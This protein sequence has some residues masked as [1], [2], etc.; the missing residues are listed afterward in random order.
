MSDLEHDPADVRALNVDRDAR[1][2]MAALVGLAEV[3]AY[4]ALILEA[5]KLLASALQALHDPSTRGEGANMVDEYT[6]QA[7]ALMRNL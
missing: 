4:P 7:R 3:H 6:R 1:N 5:A 2:V